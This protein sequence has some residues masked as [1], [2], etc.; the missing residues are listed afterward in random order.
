MKAAVLTVL[1]VA[2]LLGDVVAFPQLADK[3]L[4]E[5]RQDPAAAPPPT[6]IKPDPSWQRSPCP[7]I[8]T[9]YAPIVFQNG[10]RLQCVITLTKYRANQGFIN[11]NGTN[12]SRQSLQQAFLDAF[13]FAFSVTDGGAA[14][15]V[16]LQGRGDNTFDLSTLAIPHQIEHDG[17]LTR[18]D[19][20]MSWSNSANNNDFNCTIWSAT[21]AL[22]GKG[23]DGAGGH[24]DATSAQSA[25][26]GRFLQ[27]QQQD[28][29][30]WFTLN[31]GGSEAEA[32]FYLTLFN[33]PTADQSQGPSA[34]LDWIDYFFFNQQMPTALGWAKPANGISQDEFNGVVSRVNAAATT[35]PGAGTFSGLCGGQQPPPGTTTSSSTISSSSSSTSLPNSGPST[36]TSSSSTSVPLP[37]QPTTTSS[38]TSSSTSVPVPGQPTS[39][40]TTSSTSVPIPGQT[41]SSSSSI[42]SSN[43]PIPGQTTSTTSSTSNTI[44]T[45]PGLPVFSTTSSTS[46]TS[47]PGM[48]GTGVTNTP[49]TPITPGTYVTNPPTVPGTGLPIGTGSSNPYAPLNGTTVQTTSA[50]STN[51]IVSA[52]DVTS[53]LSG[54]SIPPSLVSASALN[55]ASAIAGSAA[56]PTVPNAYTH[57]LEKEE[58]I[59][60]EFLINHYI[61]GIEILVAVLVR[62]HDAAFSPMPGMPL[63]TMG[64]SW[65]N[66]MAPAPMPS[67]TAVQADAVPTNDN[68]LA[69]SNPSQPQGVPGAPPA[70]GALG[71][72]IPSELLSASANPAPS[73]IAGAPPAYAQSSAG[74]PFSPAMTCACP[75]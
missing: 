66:S 10:Q 32:G 4:L 35:A 48:P 26:Q 39:S 68:L 3:F 50:P 17:S 64:S 22:Y 56:A 36:T 16:N 7:G 51:T 11:R 25:R 1:A 60:V 19:R 75:S 49:P 59:Q 67:G 69:T 23:S 5:A 6:F 13:G 65:W 74:Q 18:D 43:V 53:Y 28:A 44:S 47:I 2:H 9:L 37:G 61:S 70:Q 38:S 40:S 14:N 31:D 46:S 62:F 24:V 21:L 15:A 41:T 30:G 73:G 52:T 33:D 12:V 27:A 34:R 55:Q 20:N 71:Q 57:V 63:P 58:W 45:A 72:A 42:S 54:P 8:N 29:P